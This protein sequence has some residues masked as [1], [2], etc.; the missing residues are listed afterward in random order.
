MNTLFRPIFALVY[1]CLVVAIGVASSAHAGSATWNLNPGSGD[2]NIAENWTPAT[3]PNAVGDTATF[4]LT[5]TS[6]ISISADVTVDTIT[7]T[8]EA[9]SNPYLITLGNS[10]YYTHTLTLTGDGVVNNSGT[11][12][13]IGDTFGTVVFRNNSNAG[14]ISYDVDAASFYDHSSA[15]L[16]AHRY[17]YCCCRQ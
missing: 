17:R 14:S 7:F 5:N 6:N 2:W 12:Q 15:G 13:S 1:F 10:P 9:A 8:S 16:Q 4:G 11:Q 3:V